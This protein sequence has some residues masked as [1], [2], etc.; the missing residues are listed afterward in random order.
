MMKIVLF[1]L[2]LVV[3][4]LSRTY[5]MYK[6]CDPAW[7]NDQ[8]GT[9]SNT[10]CSAGCLMSSVAMAMTATVKNFTPA[11][12]N[13]WLTQNRGY[14]SGDLFV[15]ESVNTFGITFQGKFPNSAIKAKLD[16]GC[17]ILCN[18]HNGKHWVLAY[19]YVN[20]NILIND[21]NYSVQSYSLS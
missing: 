10:I 17:I 20:D 11:N 21:P 7:K 5:P 12:L 19:G 4:A 9:S 8:L 6:Q 15:W 2:V 3:V 14:E 13:K 16:Q 1:L 18:V